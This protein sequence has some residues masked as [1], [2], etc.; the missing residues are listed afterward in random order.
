MNEQLKA[1]ADPIRL[2]I[3][4]GL[5]GGE[6]QAGDIASAFDLTRPAISHHL[7]VLTDVG[8]IKM[9][10][11]AQSRLYSIDVGAVMELRGRFNDFWDQA[12]PRLKAVAESDQ[13]AKQKRKKL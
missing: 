2:E 4:R 6:S 13:S 12:L 1:L 10:R 9:R 11:N 8:L 7:K 3:L 5:S